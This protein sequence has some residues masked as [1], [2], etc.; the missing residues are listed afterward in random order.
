MPTNFFTGLHDSIMDKVVASEVK[1]KVGEKESFQVP[2]N[3]FEDLHQSI[4]ESTEEVDL[5]TPM[6]DKLGKTNGLTIP[7]NFFEDLQ[8][9]ILEKVL[10]S[11]L[12]PSLLANADK[13]G[14][15]NVPNNFF[16]K[17]Q[18]SVIDKAIESDIKT[19]ALDYI[20]KE[21][22]FSTPDNFFDQLHDLILNEVVEQGEALAKISKEPVFSVPTNF[23][24]QLEE[25]ILTNVKES[26]QDAKVIP[27]QSWINNEQTKTTIRYIMSI[28]AMLTVFFIALQLI[29]ISPKNTKGLAN[30][31][32]NQGAELLAMNDEK[33]K[34]IL[35]E[36]SP[37]IA[38]E[39]ISENI[40]EFSDLEAIATTNKSKES[41]KLEVK[42]LPESKLIEGL[43]V[44]DIDAF[45]EENIEEFEELLEGENIQINDS[46]A[47][48][49]LTPELDKINIR[50]DDTI[51]DE[52][53]LDEEDISLF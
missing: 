46:K 51:I 28:A 27:M 42:T 5:V 36:I 17:L 14:G 11:D 4:M 34:E 15:F 12:V 13:N 44:Q 52:F 45:I 6:L 1:D 24:T 31:D 41:S 10:E 19:P 26:P 22:S 3:F 37:D 40:D 30:A 39:F 8:T 23:F 33:T 9:S 48:K 25:Q 29:D 7:T 38:E 18:E 43:D 21:P 20:S 35:D 32:A 16:E 47:S 50:I 2:T 53:G 49:E